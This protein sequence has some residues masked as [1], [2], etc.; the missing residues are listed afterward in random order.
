MHRVQVQADLPKQQIF[1]AEQ[2]KE[3]AGNKNTRWERLV[4]ENGWHYEILVIKL[5]LLKQ[6]DQR[7]RYP[8]DNRNNVNNYI[9]P[10]RFFQHFRR[11]DCHVT[12]YF[13]LVDQNLIQLAD[14]FTQQLFTT[15]QIY[16]QDYHFEQEHHV[17][18]A[19]L[20]RSFPRHVEKSEGAG[21]Q[22]HQLYYPNDDEID[23]RNYGRFL[24]Y[25]GHR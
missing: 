1:T 2:L 25:I 14:Q 19:I 12:K 21:S 4:G 9:Y 6:F 15:V 13:V 5:I 18:C 10:R 17:H 16:V 11:A 22:V 23:F 8:N 24:I 20:Q 3:N 7:R